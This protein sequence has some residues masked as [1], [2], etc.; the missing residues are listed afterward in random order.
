MAEG[1][2]RWSQ[3]SYEQDEYLK[4]GQD[5]AVVKIEAVTGPTKIGHGAVASA[6]AYAAADPARLNRSTNSLTVELREVPGK[7]L[8]VVRCYE[9][10][11]FGPKI[12]KWTQAWQEGW[13]KTREPRENIPVLACGHLKVPTEPS[14]TA[15][16]S[17]EDIAG[18][19]LRIKEACGDSLWGHWTAC[20]KRQRLTDRVDGACGTELVQGYLFAMRE[21]CGL[22]AKQEAWGMRALGMA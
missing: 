18:R 9:K 20:G 13:I 8:S 5:E 21:A 4:S 12:K 15:C 7:E 11:A 19:S 14:A 10:K 1:A 17:L 2:A 3:T 6:L 22:T 16:D